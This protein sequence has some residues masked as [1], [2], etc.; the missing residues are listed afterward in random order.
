MHTVVEK[1]S[2]LYGELCV[3]VWGSPML[4]LVLYHPRSDVPTAGRECSQVAKDVHSVFDRVLLERLSK[5][6]LE[7]SQACL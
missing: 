6:A 1:Q 3:L 2:L 4:P 5:V 7:G